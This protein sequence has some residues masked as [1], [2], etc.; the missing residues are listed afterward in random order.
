ME[1]FFRSLKSEWVP[2]M[3]Y[4]SFQKAK[5]EIIRYV[6]GYYSQVRPHRH[7]Q[8]L[9]PNVAETKYW[10]DYYSVFGGRVRGTVYRINDSRLAASYSAIET[11]SGLANR[12]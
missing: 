11:R 3:G 8:G 9:A 5:A 6:T 10:N 2:Q 1:R 12:R 7:N 4:P